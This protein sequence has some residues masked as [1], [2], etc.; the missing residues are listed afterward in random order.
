MLKNL[1][2]DYN[3]HDN[4]QKYTY[5]RQSFLIFYENQMKMIENEYKNI[6][7]HKI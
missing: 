4:L 6:E 5:P 7:H 1:K 2:F 3:F